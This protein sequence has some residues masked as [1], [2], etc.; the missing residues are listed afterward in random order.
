MPTAESTETKHS[1]MRVECLAWSNHPANVVGTRQG[2]YEGTCPMII[3]RQYR[4]N[5]EWFAG[6]YCEAPEW[7]YTPEIEWWFN[8]PTY[9]HMSRHGLY[10]G[11]MRAIGEWT[12]NHYGWR[13][14]AKS[15]MREFA[16]LANAYVFTSDTT[17]A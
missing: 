13:V 3:L 9:T 5:P 11:T 8:R 2:K 16:T 12:P 1:A 4:Q 17:N 10:V 6:P 14:W 7:C 15:A